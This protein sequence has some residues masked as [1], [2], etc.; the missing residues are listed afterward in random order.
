MLQMDRQREEKYCYIDHPPLLE[1][2]N[3]RSEIAV[4]VAVG[5][6]HRRKKA[7]RRPGKHRFAGGIGRGRDRDALP[8]AEPERPG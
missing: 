3:H 1:Q 7:G 6:V 4:Q 8:D 5:C 2:W